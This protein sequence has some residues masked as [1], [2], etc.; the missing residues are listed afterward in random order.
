MNDIHNREC[1]VASLDCVA[2]I[3]ICIDASYPL[4]SNIKLY[5]CDMSVKMTDMRIR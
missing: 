5:I 4:P 2:S 1:F 3:Y